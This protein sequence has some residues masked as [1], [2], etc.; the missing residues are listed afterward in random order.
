[1]DKEANLLFELSTMRK[2][3]RNHRPV[4]LLDDLTDNLST[5]SYLVT[6]I[7]YLLAKHE[8]ANIEKVLLMAM[9]HDIAETRTGDIA[10]INK[11]YVKAYEDEAIDDMFPAD[12]DYLNIK[13][14]LTEYA[15]RESIEAKCVKDADRMA[16]MIVLQE[17][18]FTFGNQQAK[19]WLE[20][21]EDWINSNYLT[22]YG[23]RL[24]LTVY[25]TPVNNWGKH[26]GT[27][28]RR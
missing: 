17:Q 1:M 15:K 5:H 28:K 9:S 8:K 25:K 22:E 10:W 11:M 23:R 20:K 4:L 13:T 16:Q 2:I 3:V 18:V 26:L 24:A 6:W 21:N 14:L 7:A 12:L 19:E 27:E